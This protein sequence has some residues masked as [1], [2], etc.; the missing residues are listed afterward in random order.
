MENFIS[1]SEIE[2][3]TLKGGYIPHPVAPYGHEVPKIGY[4]TQ[5]PYGVIPEYVPMV[6]YG[7]VEPPYGV[8]PPDFEQR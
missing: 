7:V 6:P 5:A 2:Q 3:M 4:L 8:N 1:L